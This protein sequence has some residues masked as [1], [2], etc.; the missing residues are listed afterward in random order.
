VEL[1]LDIL[2]SIFE[3]NYRI[4]KAINGYRALEILKEEKI[5]LVILDIIM[6]EMSGFEVLEMMKND[7]ELK[8][9]PVIIATADEG[10]NEEKALML[11]ADD[12]IKKP[13]SFV[14]VQKRVENILIKHVLERERLKDALQKTER[15]FQSLSSSVPG[16][17]CVWKSTDRFEVTYYNDGL[18]DIIGCTRKEFADL[19]MTD[20]AKLI[21]PD[22][23]KRIV[24]HFS[25]K[26]EIGNQSTL[27]YRIQ[28]RD[29]EVRWV[30]MSTVCY[31]TEGSVPVYRAVFI[32]VTDEKNNEH[33][34]EMQN[35]ELKHR[36]EYDSL[37]DVYNRY[38]FCNCVVNVL[39]DNPERDY[40]MVMMDIERFK[41][42]NE[43]YGVS[44]G[45][46]IL[47]FL[48]DFLQEHFQ[49]YGIIGRLEAD[50]FALCIP[51]N[52]ELVRDAIHM[53]QN[54]V[55]NISGVRQ[56][57]K[58]YFGIY[59]IEDRTMPVEI[60]CDRANLA[61]AEVKGQ[62]NENFMFYNN[63]LN[64]RVLLEQEMTNEMDEA[65][66]QEQ[67]EVYYQPI[68]SLETEKPVSAEALIRWIHPKKGMISP[69]AFIPFFEK[70]GFVV[71]VDEYLRKKVVEMLSARQREGKNIIP[72]SVNL[73]RLE[74][75][76][77]DF[78][79]SIYQL[80]KDAGLSPHYMRLEI[81]EGALKNHPEQLLESIRVLRAYG[82]TI[83][84]DDFGS[85][86]SS[87]NMLQEVP[88]DILKLDMQF[89]RGNDEYGRK[90]DII[91]STISM[92]HK[93]GMKTVAEGIE[94][95]EQAQF[96]NSLGCN[97]GQGFYYARPMPEKE[98]KEL[99]DQYS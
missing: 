54:N 99:L 74:F 18:C 30:K 41:V 44:V 20:F 49:E 32:D 39:K 21:Y 43:L 71:K 76:V 55:K 22:D 35:K 53:I 33:L 94:E 25:G 68:F 31:M 57:I 61:L 42:I 89:L 63:E 1:N 6:P 90:N 82:F 98:F 67:F 91:A 84:M 86:Y 17:I 80:M 16:G 7:S 2:E 59:P 8:N 92:A 72:V 58:L 81:T 62:Y 46:R 3:D 66:E 96:L 15:D 93:I 40:V 12:F 65:L 36:L 56:E 79:D 69:G 5:D 85:E 9:I 51:N 4:L 34:V 45:D 73:C 28:H 29:E 75:Y 27:I 52:E 64:E 87:L 77:P 47:C 10:E 37:T 19:Y 70:N 97:Y 38:G 11:G 23:R 60:M 14:S 24:N 83:L 26:T 78:C 48:A 95:S 88:V 13:Y 50:H